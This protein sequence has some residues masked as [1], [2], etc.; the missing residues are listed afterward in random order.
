MQ[1]N[2]Q[3]L[4][5]LTKETA[6]EY[7]LDTSLKI[8]FPINAFILDYLSL[9]DEVKICFIELSDDTLNDELNERY[10]KNEKLFKE[11]LDTIIKPLNA[12][13]EYTTVKTTFN[14]SADI[15]SSRFVELYNCLEKNCEIYADITFGAKTNTLIIYNIL[16]FAERFYDCNVEA[17]VYGKTI[18]TNSKE[19]KSV[20]NKSVAKVYDVTSLY[21]LT[22]LT[23]HINASSPEEAME[24]VKKYL[25]I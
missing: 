5:S 4:Y 21:F 3:A 16:N 6:E 2:S 25:K 12:K 8:Y 19:G 20:P 14:E 1:E 7:N 13:V 18:F 24:K 11:E 23:N 17:I 10:K 22:K 15:F 9:D